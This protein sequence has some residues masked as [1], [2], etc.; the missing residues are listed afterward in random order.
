M[1]DKS[2]QLL[3]S[4]VSRN[5]D[6]E[7]LRSVIFD[8]IENRTDWDTFFLTASKNGMLPLV[9][10]S[11]KNC[12][13][14]LLPEN[15]V[16]DVKQVIKEISMSNL[17]KVSI[18]IQLMTLLEQ[19]NIFTVPIKGPSLACTVYND[20]SLR[21]FGDLDILINIDDIVFTYNILCTSGYEP[22]IKLTPYQLHHLTRTEDNLSFIHSQTGVIVEL[23]WELSGRLLPHALTLNCFQPRLVNTKILNYTAHSLSNEDLLIYL[24]IHGSKHIWSRLEWLFSVHEIVR[25]NRDLQWDLIFTLVEHWSAKRMFGVGLLSSQYLFKT[26]FPEDVLERLRSNQ[27]TIEMAQLVTSKFLN[28]GRNDTNHR[29]NSRFTLWQLKCMDSYGGRLRLVLSMLFSPTIEDFRRVTFPEKLGFLY[30][31][32]RPLRLVWK[33]IKTV[34][35]KETTSYIL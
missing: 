6:E 14:D 15:I 7:Q 20:L 19:H 1:K 26:K 12:C 33:G 24:C 5:I 21:S 35:R 28:P 11:L 16:T 23:H 8:A 27:Q 3:I 4:S 9:H 34:Q 29:I 10:S 32:Y 30:H 17:G 13:L 25:K 2:V 18:L 31:V 22:D